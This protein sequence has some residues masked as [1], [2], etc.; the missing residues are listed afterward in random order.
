MDELIE[1]LSAPP[2]K[3]PT[4]R[5][6]MDVWL[7]G[8]TESRREAVLAAATANGWGHVSLRDKLVAYGAPALSDN[9]IREWRIKHGWVAS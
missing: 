3:R 2:A 8:Q 1:E 9:A 5:S 7:D 6:V 4:A